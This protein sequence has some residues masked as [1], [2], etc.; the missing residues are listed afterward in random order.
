MSR[1]KKITAGLP[2]LAGKD[3]LINVSLFAKLT[4]AEVYI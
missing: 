3:L 2:F 1:L 4:H